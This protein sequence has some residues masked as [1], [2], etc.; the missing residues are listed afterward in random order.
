MW[1]VNQTTYQTSYLHVVV[2]TFASAREV[3]RFH[4]FG[5]QV[6]SDFVHIV[7]DI[8]LIRGSV[9]QIIAVVLFRATVALVLVHRCTLSPFVERQRARAF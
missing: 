5:L 2:S 4:V 1:C 9:F 6:V 3:A 8:T 7:L